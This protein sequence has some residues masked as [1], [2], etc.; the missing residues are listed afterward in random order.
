MFWYEQ[1]Q[2]KNQILPDFKIE[3]LNSN[4]LD[5]YLDKEYEYLSLLNNSIIA[6]SPYNGLATGIELRRI[7]S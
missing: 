4:I 3:S 7:L 5:K 2:A 6:L 1:Y